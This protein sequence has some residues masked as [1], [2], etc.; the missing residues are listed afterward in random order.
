[1]LRHNTVRLLILILFITP[2]LSAFSVTA[3]VPLQAELA[4]KHIYFAEEN[5]ELS[6]FDRSADGLSRYAGLLNLVG[7]ELFTLE[8]RKGI[9]ADADLIVIPGPV[10]D[11]SPD[12]SARLWAYLSKGGRLLL[13]VDAID[14]QRNTSSRALSATRGFFELTWADLGIRARDDVLLRVD[15]DVP[16]TEATAEGESEGDAD[17]EAAPVQLPPLSLEFM[18][19]AVDGHPTT[20]GVGN[21]LAFRTARSIEVDAALAAAEIAPLIFGPDDFYGETSYNELVNDGLIEYNIGMDTG[22]E[23]HALAAAVEDQTS[24]LRMVLIGD[25][26]F[27]R[28]G[29]GMVTSP[30]YS[31]AFVYPDNARFLLNITAWLLESSAPDVDFATPAA[32]AT[33]TI[34]PTI[35]PT[36]T[37]T[38]TPSAEEAG[39]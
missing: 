20:N 30:I 38:P 29:S 37:M 4:G 16:P 23:R 26:D 14:E 36:P 24:G 7:A 39:E 19:E 17:A 12:Q 35:T 25:R 9:P 31:G 34:T 10:S 11:L 32:T 28:N 21:E 3:S 33:P 6:R 15:G 13:I 27:A 18:S 1:M 8:W 22:F 5:G 2:V